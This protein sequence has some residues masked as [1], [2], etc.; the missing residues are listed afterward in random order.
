MTIWDVFRKIVEGF[1]L[2]PKRKKHSS[3]YS[4]S[5]HPI[6]SYSISENCDKFY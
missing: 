6:F 4:Y 3:S 2:S 1:K 5:N